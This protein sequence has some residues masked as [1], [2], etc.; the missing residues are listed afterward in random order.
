MLHASREQQEEQAKVRTWFL[1]TP[2][3]KI[4]VTLVG[5]VTL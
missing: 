5:D 4:L 2:G 1:H 3:P